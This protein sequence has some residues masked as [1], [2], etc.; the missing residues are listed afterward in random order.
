MNVYHSD[1]FK[2]GMR[3]SVCECLI[4]EDYEAPEFYIFMVEYQECLLGANRG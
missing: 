2:S 1:V 4:D 3:L